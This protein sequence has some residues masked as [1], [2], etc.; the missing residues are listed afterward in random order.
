MA[1]VLAYWMRWPSIEGF[2]LQ[3]NGSWALFEIFHFIGL[4]LLVG[5]VVMFDLRILGMAKRVPVAPLAELLPWAVLGFV[6]AVVTGL[7][8]VL[9]LRANLYHADAYKVLMTDV[10]LQLKLIGIGLAG[11][12]LLFFYVSGMQRA[13]Y[14]LGPGEDAPGL[15]KVIAAT[16]LTLWIGVTWMGRMVPWGL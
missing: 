8:F 5:I 10:Y 11:L 9:G 2:F 4:A 12:N 14:A 6:L 13:V 1:E 7:G 16:S 3:T 15:A